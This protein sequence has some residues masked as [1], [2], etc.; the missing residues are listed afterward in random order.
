VLGKHGSKTHNGTEELASTDWSSNDGGSPT[1]ANT[2]TDAPTWRPFLL[3]ALVLYL[4]LATS[5]AFFV[6]GSS[7]CCLRREWLV[8]G[9]VC[10]LSAAL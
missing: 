8:S 1:A 6:A 7:V 10:V 4:A 9:C 5:A 2:T 3:R